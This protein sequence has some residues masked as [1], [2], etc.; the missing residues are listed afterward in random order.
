MQVQIL[1]IGAAE[2]LVFLYKYKTRGS[3]AE[4][5]GIEFDFKYNFKKLFINYNFSFVEGNNKS[6]N[7][8]LSFI[9]PNKT[10]TIIRL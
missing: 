3:K 10:N 4:I 1:L 6:I 7:R 9:N 8:P 2:S 5:K